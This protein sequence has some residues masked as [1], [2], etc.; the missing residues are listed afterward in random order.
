MHKV[1]VYGTLRREAEDQTLWYVPGMA[2]YHFG[3]FPGA[4]KS[5]YYK[6]IGQI[7]EV[8]DKQL[9]KLDR[10]EALDAGLYTRERVC[11]IREDGEPGI[12]T[13]WIYLAG[14]ELIQT[15][16]NC[17]EEGFSIRIKSGDWNEAN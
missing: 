5:R 14:E 3:A 2:L 7:M 1:F 4:V 17:R 12:E 8:D 13:V 11:C 15:I 6:T 16:K 9:A 10:Y